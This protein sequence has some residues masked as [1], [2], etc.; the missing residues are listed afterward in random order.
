MYI[1]GH[2]YAATNTSTLFHSLAYL[3]DIDHTT[4]LTSCFSANLNNSYSELKI[5][6]VDTASEHLCPEAALSLAT[7]CAFVVRAG[8]RIDS[9]SITH[10]SKLGPERGIGADFRPMTYGKGMQGSLEYRELVCQRIGMR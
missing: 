6:I 9:D 10:A 1:L 5:K 7:F 4:I 2:F 8:K 3:G